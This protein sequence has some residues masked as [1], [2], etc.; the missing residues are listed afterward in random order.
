MSII[1]Q[2]I[3]VLNTQVGFLL[4]DFSLVIRKEGQYIIQ[5]KILFCQSEKKGS[6]SYFLAYMVS[7]FSF[8]LYFI[9]F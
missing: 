9:Y 1:Y 4:T 7:N 3:T 2:Y 8:F 5:D 6:F